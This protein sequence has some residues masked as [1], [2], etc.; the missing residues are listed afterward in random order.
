MRNFPRI[1]SQINRN[2]DKHHWKNQLCWI[3]ITFLFFLG[4]MFRT[5]LHDSNADMEGYIRWYFYIKTNGIFDALGDN[6]AIYTP[7]YTYLLS[8]AT[9]MPVQPIVAIKLIPIIMD[10]VN[11]FIIYKIVQYKYLSKMTSLLASGI[12]LCLPTIYINSTI[13]GQI[14][15]IYTGFLLL[16]LYFLIKEQ[17][18]WGIMAFSIAFVFKAQAVFIAPLLV[19]LFFKKHIKFWHFFLIPGVYIVFCLPTVLLGRSLIDVLTIYLQQGNDLKWL[20]AN[21]PNFYHY[22]P[23]R[24]YQPVVWI[25][26]VVAIIGI[27]SWIIFTLKN[28]DPIDKEKFML[29]ALI[30]VVLMPFLLPKMHD[31]YFYPADVFSL[32]VAFYMPELWFLPI[33]YQIVSGFSYIPFL[34]DSGFSFLSFLQEI[35][36]PSLLSV[37]ISVN[38]I[39]LIFLLRKQFR[40]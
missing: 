12:Y 19:V 34:I 38:L 13:W 20:S 14:D 17:P 40:N 16:A 11:A 35:P 25:G 33:A 10:F 37:A 4:V 23:N 32:V 36:G 18:F 6:F 21:T 7:P 39:S 31:R 9:F 27:G 8:L 30:S 1:S 5:H 28:I 15:G 29:L 22:I 26:I 3:S 2:M 24:Y